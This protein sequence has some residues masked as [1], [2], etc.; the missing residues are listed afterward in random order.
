MVMLKTGSALPVQDHLCESKQNFTPGCLYS[1]EVWIFM[2]NLLVIPYTDD[3]DD[4]DDDGNDKDNDDDNDYNDDDD[5]SF[6]H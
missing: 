6:T 5:E 2:N 3:D 1:L 4:D